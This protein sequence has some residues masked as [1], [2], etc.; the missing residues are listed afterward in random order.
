MQD[1]EQMVSLLLA[2]VQFLILFKLKKKNYDEVMNLQ[3]SLFP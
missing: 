1:E 3:K 2:P